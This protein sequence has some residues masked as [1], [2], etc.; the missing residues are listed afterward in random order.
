MW[1]SDTAVRPELA[2]EVTCPD[3]VGVAVCAAA[4]ATK[5]RMADRSML[6]GFK[7]KKTAYT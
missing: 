2:V 6:D 5:N 1:Q 4:A 7:I 3:E